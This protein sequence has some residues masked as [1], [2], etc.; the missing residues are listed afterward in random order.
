LFRQAIQSLGAALEI[1]FEQ[2]DHGVGGRQKGIAR[3]HLLFEL[4]LQI[5]NQNVI[6]IPA[7]DIYG[8]GL[9]FTRAGLKFRDEP[10]ILEYLREHKI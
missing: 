2:M 9:H 8:H 1:V 3:L 5:W 7:T 4:E 6:E 10:Q